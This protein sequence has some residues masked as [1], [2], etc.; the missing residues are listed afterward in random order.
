[1]LCPTLGQAL[2]ENIGSL[3]CRSKHSSLF[4][5]IVT[6]DDEA[7]T[8]WGFKPAKQSAL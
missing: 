5:L 7:E 3:K 4:F 8:F 2:T 1:M 6:V